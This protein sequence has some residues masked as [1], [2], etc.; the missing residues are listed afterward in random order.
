[1]RPNAVELTA[2]QAW[3]LA[4]RSGA[5]SFPWVLAITQPYTDVGARRAFDA[6]QTEEL[7][8]IGVVSTDGV[9]NHA[10]E[11]WIRLICRPR[12]WL[13]LRWVSAGGDL[14]RGLVARDGDHTVVALRNADRFTCT[15]LD[16]SHPQGL[17]PV[18]TAG[19]NGRAP[20]RFDEL[21]LPA[22]VG[23]KADERIRKGESLADVMAY[24]GISAS[25]RPVVEAAF[26]AGRSYVEVVAGEHCHGHRVSTPVGFSIVDT[27]VGRVVV[28][29]VEAAHGQWVS[30]FQPGTDLAV[31]V[32]AQQLTAAL[33]E[34]PWFPSVSLTRDFEQSSMERKKHVPQY[35]N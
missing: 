31:A 5:G 28:R 11:Q 12:R 15:E 3:L 24:L 1:M 9:L 16:I 13:E 10:V 14:L 2:A 6:E 26:G 27:A 34:G 4:E 7:T 21:T 35:I 29:P 30:I 18:L 20:A 25:A 23:A 22:H 8:R 17:V 33:P 32:A 19:L